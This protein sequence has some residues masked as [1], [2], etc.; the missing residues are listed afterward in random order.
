[1]FPAVNG[2]AITARSLHYGSALKSTELFVKVI[3]VFSH[4][5]YMCSYSYD[6]CDFSTVLSA[7]WVFINKMK[8][9]MIKIFSC[10]ENNILSSDNTRES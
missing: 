1:M 4:Q 7:D 2:N 3:H 5:R 6:V 10:C 8:F 9:K